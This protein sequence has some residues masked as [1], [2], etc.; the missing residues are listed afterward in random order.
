MAA[1]LVIAL[2]AFV[3][4][5][6]ND[7]P[8][9]ANVTS[10]AAIVEQNRE[11]EVIVRDQQAPHVVKLQP[12]QPA[13]AG[14][15]A[16]VVRYMN[17]QIA[18]GAIDGPIRSSWCHLLA[19]GTETRQLLRCGVSASGVTYPFDGVAQPGAGVAT[20][21]QRVSPPVPSMNVPISKRCT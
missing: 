17:V 18:H 15:R 9:I 16:A 4:H 7:V 20:F 21:C 8:Q 1:V 10:K 5:Q 6:T 11:D 3:N 19:G 12:G 14:M 13:A 2:V